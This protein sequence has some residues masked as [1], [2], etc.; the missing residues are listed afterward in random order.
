[1]FAALLSTH[2]WAGAWTLGPGHAYSKLSY[3]FYAASDRFDADGQQRPLNDAAFLGE[4]FSQR[5]FLGRVRDHALRF[6][7]EI[8]LFKHLD[9]LGGL[10][11]ISSQTIYYCG[12]PGA[13]EL[14]QADAVVSA[15]STAEMEN[16][17]FGDLELGGKLRLF[18]RPV[19]S[20]A[21]VTY[22]PTYSNDLAALRVNDQSIFNDRTPLG[23][24]AIAAEGRALFG[25]SVGDGY[26]DAEIGYRVRSEGYANLVTYWLEAG[27]PLVGRLRGS[28]AL[29]G[30]LALSPGDK[31]DA[32][33]P[34]LAEEAAGEGKV[35][36]PSDEAA[37]K[38]HPKLTVAIWRGLALELGGQWVYA[39]RRT[40]A[41]FGVDIAV[42]L[43]Q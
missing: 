24:G 19:V 5:V 3:S 34:P 38:I 10:S 9:L 17:G 7:G 8:G 15:E 40:N 21:L 33:E 1:M 35:L 31:P 14:C 23:S 6:Y 30:F 25:L 27:R 28:M 41:A 11:W 42:S 43:R 16:R 4:T 22:W 36:Y 12:S 13:P 29:G 20:V 39:G 32:H 26:M 18:E 2:A 37:H